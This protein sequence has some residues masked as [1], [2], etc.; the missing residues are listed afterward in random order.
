MPRPSAVPIDHIL[1]AAVSARAGTTLHR[2]FSDADLPRVVEAG[3]QPGSA[4]DA[5]LQFLEMEGKVAIDGKLS[6]TAT[7]T[8]QRCMKPAAVPLRDEFHVV[9]VSED[10]AEE[11]GGYEPVVANSARLDV[12]WLIEEQTLLA[13]PL[14]P[15]HE[16]DQCEQVDVDVQRVQTARDPAA[17][18]QK[19]FENLRDLLRKHS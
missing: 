15:M 11:L 6:G 9:L 5:R 1:D 16:E 12:R 10:S 7:L 18:T 3:A 8:C 13:L 4:I 14:V 17:P 19:P 2:S